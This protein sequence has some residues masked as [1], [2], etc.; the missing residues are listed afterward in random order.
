MTS[1]SSQPMR[2]MSN[3][4][5]CTALAVPPYG[6]VLLWT[7]LA[8]QTACMFLAEASVLIGSDKRK[9]DAEGALEEV[10]LALGHPAGEGH[11]LVG[12]EAQRR[13]GRRRRSGRASWTA[14][15]RARSSCSVRRSSA[16]PRA[17]QVLV[18]LARERL[19]LAERRRALA[20]VAGE[21]GDQRGL[22]R[23]EARQPGVEDQVARVLVVVVVVDRRADVVQHRRRPQQVALGG[24]AACAGRPRASASHISSVS[25]A[26]CSVCANS[27]WYCAARLSTDA[28]RTSS[29][30]GGSVPASSVSKKTPSRRPASVA[31]IASNSPSSITVSMTTRGGEDDVGA[32]G[33]DAVDRAALGGRHVDH[34]VD[35][36]AERACASTR[37]ALDAEVGQP[38]GALRGR[39]E[40]ADRAADA[41]QPA[42]RASP[43]PA[44]QSRP[45]EQLLLHVRAQRLDLLGRRR[46]AVQE[47]LRH[48]HRAHPP[49][50][51]VGRPCG[52]RRA[53]AAASRRRCRAR[54]RRPASSS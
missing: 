36:L 44:S 20:V 27:G 33:L 41:D 8:L 18:A 31:S 48:A 3:Q 32:A 7:S 12:G 14:W 39:R 9:P 15:S 54:R 42:R 6:Q 19:E 1:P 21:L 43:A 23:R 4:L 45:A 29:N 37:H 51:R 10:G 11:V 49:R 5:R 50:A 24:V 28:R 25:S 13:R 53:S 26:T 52:P 22:A 47:A 35:Q 16:A 17:Q 30:S 2:S 40:V 38:G 46:L 34:R